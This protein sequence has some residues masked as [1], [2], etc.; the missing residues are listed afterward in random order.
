MLT[1]RFALD[2]QIELRADGRWWR[3]DGRVLLIGDE[4][5]RWRVG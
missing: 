4:L 3:A 5:G 1:T 2:E